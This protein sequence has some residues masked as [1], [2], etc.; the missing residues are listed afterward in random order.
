[1][2]CEK[3][4]ICGI[5]D[6]EDAK[7]ALSL[8]AD[9]LGFNFYPGSK[10]YIEPAEA[11]SIVRSLPASAWFVGVF[12]NQ[13]RSEIEHIARLVGLD[14][15]QFHGDEDVAFCEGWPS[16]QVIKAIRVNTSEDILKAKEYKEVADFLLL[17]AYS[18]KAFGGTGKEIADTALIDAKGILSQSF[19]AGG[20]TAENVANKIQQFAPFGVD[21]ASGVEAA[22]RKKSVEKL[23]AFFEE[24]RG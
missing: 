23:Q 8:G 5:C 9:A 13:G 19:L 2:A 21:V 3:I 6:L 22:P 16:W 18:D 1:M 10:R 11:Q 14:T 20:L 17:D 12:V 4:K 7:L 24:I 15:L